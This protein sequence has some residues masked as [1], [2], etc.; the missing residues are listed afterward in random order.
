MIKQSNNKLQQA[1]QKMQES[2]REKWEETL[3]WDILQIIKHLGYF[4]VKIIT[5][6]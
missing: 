2:G 1:F 6:I 5:G 3:F 4:Y